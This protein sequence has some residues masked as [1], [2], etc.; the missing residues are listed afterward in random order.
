MLQTRGLCTG[1]LA[2]PEEPSPAPSPK[3]RE[4][5]LTQQLLGVGCL[6]HGVPQLEMVL[7]YLA[8]NSMT[9]WEKGFASTLLHGRIPSTFISF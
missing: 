3:Q 6:C 8:K 9:F 7:L 5:P 1:T 2:L 4:R